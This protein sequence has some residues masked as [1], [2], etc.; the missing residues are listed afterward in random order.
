MTGP[1]RR[2]R[3]TTKMSDEDDVAVVTEVIGGE[4]GTHRRPC[5]HLNWIFHKVNVV[6]QVK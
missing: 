2:A 1:D 6:F 5:V 3:D 4:S